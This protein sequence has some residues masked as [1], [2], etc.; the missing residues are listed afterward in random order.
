MLGPEDILLESRT[1][2]GRYDHRLRHIILEAYEA[3]GQNAAQ[4]ARTLG[5]H[6]KTVYAHVKEARGR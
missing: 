6:R 4:T 2:I 1:S 5:M 3:S